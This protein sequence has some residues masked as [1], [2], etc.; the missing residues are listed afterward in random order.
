GAAGSDAGRDAAAEGAMRRV[1]TRAL[2]ALP[3]LLAACNDERAAIE[4]ALDGDVLE[5]R[6]RALWSIAARGPDAAWSVPRVSGALDGARGGGG[7]RVR[8]RRCQRAARAVA[9]DA[10]FIVPAASRRRMGARSRA[11]ARCR[12]ARRPRVAA[13][14]RG[15]ADAPGGGGGAAAPVP[16]TSP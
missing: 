1:A 7:G 9:R 11:G 13:R 6:Q 3:F 14:G 15:L 4:A 12:S 16:V 8:S 10:R 2:C 5:L